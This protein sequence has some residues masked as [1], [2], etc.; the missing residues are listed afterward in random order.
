MEDEFDWAEIFEG[1]TWF[2]LSGITLA[3]GEKVR[4]VALRACQEAVKYHVPI[5]FDFNYRSKLWTI[6]VAKPVYK[7]FMHYFDVVLHR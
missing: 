5:S 3:L 2:H 4:K 6:D 1:A 7:K